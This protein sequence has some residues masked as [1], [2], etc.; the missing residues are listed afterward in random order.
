VP[1]LLYPLPLPNSNGDRTI[2]AS[3]TVSTFTSH[4]SMAMVYK[5]SQW[6]SSYRAILVVVNDMW[7]AKLQEAENS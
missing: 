1:G 7:V 5:C 2:L 3:S 6:L 4:S